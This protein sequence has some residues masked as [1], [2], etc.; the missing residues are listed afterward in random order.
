MK[1]KNENS[2]K[3]Y[4]LNLKN[5]GFSLI[6]L[7]IA[8]VIISFL[9]FGGFYYNNLKQKQSLIETGQDAKRQAEKL[10]KIVEERNKEININGLSE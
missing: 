1:S 3:R 6:G 7:I 5:N 9:V 10:N 4:G 2:K 8:L